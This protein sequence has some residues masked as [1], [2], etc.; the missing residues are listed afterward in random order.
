MP[1]IKILTA[2]YLISAPSLKYCPDLNGLPEFALVG[3]SNV[4]K[5]SFING[6]LGRKNLARTSNTPGKT[7]HINFYQVKF[8]EETEGAQPQELVFTD[9]P[10]YGYAKVSK[11]EQAQWRT[12]LE[13]YLSKRESLKLVIQ[14]VDAR[15]G[16]QPNDQQMLEWLQYKQLPVLLV[17]TKLDKLS[18][19]EATKS[20]QQ[21]AKALKLP[22]EQLIGFSAISGQGKAQSWEALLKLLS[23]AD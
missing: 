13:N 8:M 4:G 1:P 12:N 5:S 7:R 21:T 18:K 6:L 19:N 16:M 11:S 3:R 20:L 9:L 17:L 10:G 2:Q 15:H 22:P 23:Q 14:L